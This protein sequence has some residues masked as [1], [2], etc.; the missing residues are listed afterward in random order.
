M[1][2]LDTLSRC[3]VLAAGYINFIYHLQPNGK[4][5]LVSHTTRLLA[6]TVNI[7]YLDL[8]LRYFIPIHSVRYTQSPTIM[9]GDNLDMG[10]VAKSSSFTKDKSYLQ[11]LPLELRDMIYRNLL[12]S[13]EV[14]KSKPETGEVT[15]EFQPAILGVNHA[16]R[17][18]TRRV[19]CNENTFVMFSTNYGLMT[20]SLKE[21]G[22][23]FISNHDV[24]TFKYHHL[25]VTLRLPPV[26]NTIEPIGILGV[27]IFLMAA[28]DLP[29][30]IRM[31]KIKHQTSRPRL[32]F[33]LLLKLRR[34]AVDSNLRNQRIQKA[35]LEPFKQLHGGICQTVIEGTVDDAYRLE[36]ESIIQPVPNSLAQ[37]QSVVRL[38]QDVKKEA[39]MLFKVGK[40]D[41]AT[42]RY[43]VFDQ[44]R[45][46]R[47]LCLTRDREL[48]RWDKAFNHLI[49]RAQFNKWLVK[50]RQRKYTNVIPDLLTAIE[51]SDYVT[52]APIEPYYEAKMWYYLALATTGEDL[53]SELIEEGH[54]EVTKMELVN[55]YLL[56]ASKLAPE[57]ENI[58]AFLEILK[59]N[60][61]TGLHGG[62]PDKIIATEEIFEEDTVEELLDKED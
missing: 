11:Q 16:I 62:K 55:E 50:L 43:Y 26:F 35:L 31:I 5:S 1:L 39:D 44:M 42:R 9:L 29:R 51:I 34:V 40:F 18:E 21:E 3:S 10:M 61:W 36:V 24:A 8:S 32:V 30:L 52:N 38:A 13:S 23:P 37:L 6:S 48:Q 49:W 53:G 56:E 46:R 2:C 58:K 27:Q 20:D 15:Y 41:Q 25:H 4:S 59:N 47:P 12:L 45:K 57:D 17:S 33:S 7:N 60:T 22:V 54:I 28:Q 19:F 14:R